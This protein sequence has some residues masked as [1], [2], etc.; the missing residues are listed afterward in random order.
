M[1]TIL[2]MATQ[3]YASAA[4][5][6][7]PN[8]I[9]L[10]KARKIIMYIILDMIQFLPEK[11]QPSTSPKPKPN[12]IMSITLIWNILAQSTFLNTLL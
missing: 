3:K 12:P 11:Y 8:F 10:T 6:S 2:Q 4:I 7:E 9:I 1:K 5:R